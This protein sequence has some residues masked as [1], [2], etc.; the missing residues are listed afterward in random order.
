MLFLPDGVVVI[1]EGAFFT[2]QSSAIGLAMMDEEIVDLLM[3][4]NQTSEVKTYL[5]E[6]L[7]LYKLHTD[8]EEK[9]NQLQEMLENL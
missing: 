6:A 8:N 7:E 5:E 3:K 2:D 4:T 1:L 9:I